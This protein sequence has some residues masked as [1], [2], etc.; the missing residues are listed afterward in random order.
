MYDFDVLDKML[1]DANAGS[2]AAE[3]HGFLCA[4]ICVAG[5]ITNEILSEYLLAGTVDDAKIDECQEQMTE[6]VM[7]ITRQMKSP[8]FELKLILPDDDY[9]LEERGIALV[10]WCQG[11]L[12][13]LGVAGLGSIEIISD[14]SKELIDDLYK[15]SRLSTDELNDYA[16]EGESDLMELIEYVRVGMFLIYDEFHGLLSDSH[17]PELLH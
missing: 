14:E 11:F 15:I 6:L 13:G 12:S 8:D 2:R 7:E 10:E 9:S 5:N 4:Q 1:E 17:D 16:E 3:C